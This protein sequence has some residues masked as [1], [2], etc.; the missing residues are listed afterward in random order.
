[1]IFI[2]GYIHCD[3]HPGNVLV[4]KNPTTGS[5]DIILLD[6]GLY[7]TLADEFRI[8]YCSLWMALLKADK[9][10]IKVNKLLIFLF[11]SIF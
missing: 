6:H 9:D 7:S 4:Q 8:D 2:K 10:A 1:M 5:N 3:P 11:L